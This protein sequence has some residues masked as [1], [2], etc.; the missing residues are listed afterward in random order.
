[1]RVALVFLLLLGLALTGPAAGQVSTSTERASREISRQI[2]ARYPVID[3]PAINDR[4]GAIV[5]RLGPIVGGDGFSWQFRVIANPTPNAF[6]LPNGYIY[7]HEGLLDGLPGNGPLT[8]DE[9]AF[10]LAHEM[11]HV[12]LNH[13]SRESGVATSIQRLINRSGLVRSQVTQ[14]VA[15]LLRGGVEASYSRELETEADREALVCTA[16]AGY[17]PEAALTLFD[18]MQQYQQ[19]N[20]VTLRLFHTHPKAADRYANVRGWLDKRATTATGKPAPRQSVT[21]VVVV[22][23]ATAAAL[24]APPPS[25]AA[26]SATQATDASALPQGT[27]ACLENPAAVPATDVPPPEQAGVAAAPVA[28]DPAPPA[29]AFGP[30]PAAPA[31]SAQRVVKAI[32]PT[33]DFTRLVTLPAAPPPTDRA[34][35]QQAATQR[36]ADAILLLAVDKLE[37][38]TMPWPDGV[39]YSVD[40]NLT[41][42][43]LRARGDDAPERFALHATRQATLSAQGARTREDVR[44]ETVEQ[45]LHGLITPLKKALR[46]ASP[47]A[48]PTQTQPTP[49][50][51]LP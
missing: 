16:Q 40:V 4:V 30:A 21:L 2:E 12:V 3:D 42:L 29:H 31:L 24:T 44:Y 22:D 33:L 39:V 32:G 25:P 13:G 14:L 10:V 27:D 34:A 11:M 9:L 37:Q 28:A 50:P 17:K 1:M 47:P 36:G 6:A 5:D 41:A 19:S 49:A 48:P 8:D 15:K 43:L 20:G 46:P 7:V 18:R 38:Q 51:P 26:T 35:L 45:A 23:S